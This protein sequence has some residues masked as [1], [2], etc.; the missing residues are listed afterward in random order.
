M[1]RLLHKAAA[2]VTAA[3]IAL[4]VASAPAE[5]V[6]GNLVSFGDSYVANPVIRGP[7]TANMTWTDGCIQ[8]PNNWPRRA[9]AAKGMPVSDYSCNGIT[10]RRMLSRIDSAI[11][12]GDLNRGTRVVTISI[13]GNNYWKPGL[14]DGVFVPSHQIVVDNYLRDMDAAMSKI[15]GAAPNAKI[16]M[17][18]MLSVTEPQGLSGLCWYHAKGPSVAGFSLPNSMIG[19]PAWPV[20]AVEQSLQWVQRETAIRHGLQFVDIKEMSKWNNTCAPDNIRYVSG[21]NDSVAE[22]HMILHPTNMGTQFVADRVAE[23]I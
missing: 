19:F 21:Y 17:V 13:G 14:E 12:H 16:L 2:A 6:T 23:A 11:A 3:A 8:G 4:G 22:Y 15:R 9:G 5:A 10:S 20:Q 7:E 18:G 1:K